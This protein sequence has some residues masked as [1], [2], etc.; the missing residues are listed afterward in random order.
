MNIL[1]TKSVFQAKVPNSDISEQEIGDSETKVEQAEEAE[2]L[3]GKLSKDHRDD[4]LNHTVLPVDEKKVD[5]ARVLTDAINN[6]ISSFTPDFSF[7][8]MVKDYKTARSI[9]GDTMIRELTQ[10]DP[11]YIDRNINVPEFQR[12]L[13]NRL[14]QNIERLKKDGL[15]E[16]DGSISD[17]G[18]E[19]SALSMLQEEL[20]NLESKGMQ[21]S[22][23]NKKTDVYGEKKDYKKYESSDRYRDIS[24]RKTVRSAIR[25]GRQTITREDLTSN[26]RQAKGKLNVIYCLDA[27]GSMKGQKIKMA[28]RAGIAL[29]YKATLNKDKAGLLV[30][31][32]KIESKV[33][34]TTDF[35]SIL[36]GINKIRTAGETDIALGITDAL[37]MFNERGN[38][39]L[40][41]L[42]DAVQTLG[43]KPE[44]E[45]LKKISEATNNK[46]TITLIG[47]NLDKEG[48]N[49][50]QKIVNINNG[51]LYQVKSSDD[52]GHIVIEDYNQAKKS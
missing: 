46:V 50:A 52:L 44:E 19:Y 51:R 14:Q 12:E 27:S 8:Q 3:T 30:F 13:K 25:R 34:L 33:E 28:K 6:N 11:G 32:S 15:L 23:E 16:K 42:T 17:E 41:L 1:K 45:V 20:D 4:K 9:Y 21:G 49:L 48:N 26:T 5:D 18:Y 38:N 10:Y 39:H 47:I 43:K 29:A 22:T 36:R 37:K 40:V 31:S 7:E 24:V 35:H 2:E